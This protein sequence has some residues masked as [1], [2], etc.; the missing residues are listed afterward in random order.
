M[1]KFRRLSWKH[2]QLGAERALRERFRP[3]NS[4]LPFARCLRSM[5]NN[6]PLSR[7]LE[8]FCRAYDADSPESAMRSACSSLLASCNLSKPAIPLKAHLRKLDIELRRVNGKRTNKTNG[9]V[10]ARLAAKT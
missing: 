7:G 3:R 6:T 10:E 1:P 4:N 5:A 2:W 8:V 9:Q